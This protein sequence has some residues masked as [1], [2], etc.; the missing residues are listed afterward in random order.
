MEFDDVLHMEDIEKFKK[1]PLQERVHRLS[2][3]EDYPNL[4]V[5]L[6]RILA[7]KP[8]SAD[9]ERLIRSSVV[10]KSPD[11]SGMT[12]QTEDFYLYVYYIYN[13][14][15]IDQWDPR[16]AVWNWMDAKMHRTRDRL[17]GKQQEY[18]KGIFLEATKPK[19]RK[20]EECE[21]DPA[22]SRKKKKIF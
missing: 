8:H 18:F 11:R 5:T 19:K 12:L 9:V 15:P 6:A 3:S 7:A 13:M 14:P 21:E 17:K 10:L 22:P 1:L 20:L 4:K 2:Q 16:P